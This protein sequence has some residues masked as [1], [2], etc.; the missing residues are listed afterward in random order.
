MAKKKKKTDLDDLLK[1]PEPKEVKTKLPKSPEKC[2]KEA[3]KIVMNPPE[4]AG[5]FNPYELMSGLVV[6]VD[7]DKN[8]I[9]LLGAALEES[10]AAISKLK[11]EVNVHANFVTE[12]LD[13]VGE[14]FEEM[15]FEGKD[16]MLK[17]IEASYNRYDAIKA[18]YSDIDTPEINKLLISSDDVESVRGFLEGM[19]KKAQKNLPC[20]Y[21][22]EIAGML[23]KMEQV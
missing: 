2:Y 7:D 3:K 22:K 23:E 16:V 18:T 13:T 21:E 5:D 4:K 19:L 14:H 6:T 1:T 8:N 12:V 15:D 17:I 10:E 11:E 20:N 9:S